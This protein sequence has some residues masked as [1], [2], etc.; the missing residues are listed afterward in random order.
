[1]LKKSA[2]SIV[3]QETSFAKENIQNITQS[4]KQKRI[5]FAGNF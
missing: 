1:M 3:K 4:K 2:E 5:P